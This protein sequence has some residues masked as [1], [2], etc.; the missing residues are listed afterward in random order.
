[1][2]KRKKRE[3]LG[4]GLADYSRKSPLNADEQDT[5]QPERPI[6]PAE[7]LQQGRKRHPSQAEGERA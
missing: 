1:M 7:D 2:F 6:K 4:L 3:G 5:P